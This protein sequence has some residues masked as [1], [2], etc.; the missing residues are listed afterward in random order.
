MSIVN[1][2]AKEV[3][4]LNRL[5]TLT[6]KMGFGTKVSQMITNLNRLEAD[7]SVEGTPV[8][9]VNAAKSLA[10]SGVVIAGETITINNPAVAG[11]D[12]YEFVAG[13]SPAAGHIAVDIVASTVKATDN[14][15]VDAQPTSGDT[16]TIGAKAY[17]FVPD[18]TANADGEISVGTN[19]STAQANIVAAI[20]GTDEVNNPHPLVT[21]GT[22]A[23]N[24]SAI[25]AIIGGAA[26]NDIVTTETF[27]AETNIF[28]AAKL[29]TGSDCIAA[30]AITA[31]VAAVTASDTQGVGAADGAGD[32]VDWTAD[33]AGVIGNAIIIA[34][35][36]AN[37]AF[38]GAA[39]TLSGGIN[40]TV[41]LKGDTK[42]D[43][44]YLYKCVADNTISGKNWRRISLGSAY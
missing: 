39:T 34:E 6:K 32:T 37:G 23:A 14:L 16:M 36:M 18:G 24:V 7:P 31:L 19:L 25:T 8:N 10:V 4:Q 15:T 11:T 38:A 30:N 12:V 40:G 42:M 28:S 27:T 9:A 44:S 20:N 41:G 1:F 5:N 43:A 2:T 21:A 17:I 13:N 3:T 33:T 22:F 26:G 35:T 29:A